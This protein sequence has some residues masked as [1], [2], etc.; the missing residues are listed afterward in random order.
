MAKNKVN[1]EMYL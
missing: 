1:N